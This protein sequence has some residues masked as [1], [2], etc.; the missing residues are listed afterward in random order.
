M[1]RSRLLGVVATVVMSV[2][3][4]VPATAADQALPIVSIDTSAFP[5]VRMV[6]AAPA[7]LRDETLTASAFGVTENGQDR[8]VQLE[9]LPPGQ[10]EVGLVIDTSASMAGAP[11]VA[12]KAAAQS[13]LAQLPA[14]VPVSVVG[15]GRA[16]EVVSARSLDRTAQSAAITALRA[17]GP[18][19][20]Y[21]ALTTALTQLPADTSTRRALVLLTD[22][23]DTASTTTLEATADALDAADVP[24]FAVELRSPES[25]SVALNRLTSASSGQVVQAEDPA[26]LA[27]A[28]DVVAAQLVRRYVL[29][30]RSEARGTTNVDVT[31]EASDVRATAHRQVELPAE[32]LPSLTPPRAAEATPSAPL[33]LWALILG[34]I[35]CAAALFV[36]LLGLFGSRPPRARGL[37]ARRRTL[38]LA[39]AA[40]RAESLGDKV[41]RRRGGA[42]VS[43]ALEAAGVDVRPGELVAGV[44]VL[45]LALLALGWLLI[46]PLGGLLMAGAV[47]LLAMG[48]LRFLAGRRRKR[49]SDQLPETLQLLSGSLRAGHGLAQG[50]DTIAREAESPT[51]EEFRRLTIE[52]RLGRDFVDALGALADRMGGPDFRWVIQAIEIQRDV[53][54]D[55][56]EVLDTVADTIRDRTRIRRQAS[57]LS[58]EGRMSAWVL[59]ALPFGLAAV[60][61][62]TNP[63]FLSPLFRT[64][65]GQVLLAVGA[66]LMVVGALWLKKIV[67]PIF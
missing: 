41:L 62:V 43:G 7:G 8:D 11:L 10:V 48:V 22:G 21:D 45:D 9:P 17:R 4:A 5:E 25:N 31:L 19:A 51:A 3:L 28:F 40:D 14:S 30:Y 36:L 16:P 24:L 44:V 13:L 65:T 6:V 58:A 42:R 52:A 33:G 47:P 27:G 46:G 18:T 66:A 39:D 35:L 26:A 59:I 20:L 67:K 38:G 54:G 56:A 1:I 34:G 12:A 55:L 57:A 32:P 53:G 49:F 50:I 61:A 29:T 64:G 60:M 23:G 37:T 63:G 2:L 15:F